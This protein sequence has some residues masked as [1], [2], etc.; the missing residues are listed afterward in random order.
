MQ[1]FVNDEAVRCEPGATLATLL[2]GRGVMTGGVAVA[3]DGEVAP[4][5]TWAMVGLTEG[6]S[7]L[8]IKASQGG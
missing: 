4:R 5:E 6:C 3:V 1:V 7:V 2:E 8:I